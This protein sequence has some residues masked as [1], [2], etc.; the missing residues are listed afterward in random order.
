LQV[1]EVH[2]RNRVSLRNPV[3]LYLSSEFRVLA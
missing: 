1:Y 3:S 2:K